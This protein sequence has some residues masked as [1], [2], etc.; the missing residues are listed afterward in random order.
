VIGGAADVKGLEADVVI[1]ESSRTL[2]DELEVERAARMYVAASRAR[3]LLSVV[4][5]ALQVDEIADRLFRAGACVETRPT[6]G[7]GRRLMPPAG[8]ADE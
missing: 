7:E 2:L 1:V 8:E 5:P 6:R 3:A 4:V